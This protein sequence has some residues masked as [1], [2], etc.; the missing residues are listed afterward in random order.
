M[1]EGEEQEESAEGIEMIGTVW[2][3]CHNRE[4]TKL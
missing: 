4:K 2:S 3:V 1:D